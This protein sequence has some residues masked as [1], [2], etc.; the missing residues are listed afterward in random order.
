MRNLWDRINLKYDLNPLDEKETKGMIS[1]RIKQAGYSGGA[2]ALF[3]DD[4]ISEI[5]QCTRGYPR[6]IAMLCH[7]ALKELVMEN[8]F[9]VNAELIRGL[10]AG[11]VRINSL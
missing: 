2:G 6:R 1:F 8:K 7:Q 5:Y 10:I 11:E 3:S 9:T 4:A